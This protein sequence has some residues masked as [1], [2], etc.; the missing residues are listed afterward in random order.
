MKWNT[1][2]LFYLHSDTQVF[3]AISKHY[4]DLI[5]FI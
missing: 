4:S 2:A 1:Y 3:S 5:I